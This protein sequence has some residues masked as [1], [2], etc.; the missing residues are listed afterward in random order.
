MDRRKF[1]RASGLL[2]LSL[3]LPSVLA[4]KEVGMPLESVTPVFRVTTKTHARLTG[5]K[6]YSD[7]I[8]NGVPIK[9]GTLVKFPEN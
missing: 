7:V 3:P 8:M 5:I 2:C 1:L 9:A 6:F 4:A